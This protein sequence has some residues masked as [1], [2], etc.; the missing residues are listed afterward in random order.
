MGRH[1]DLS[2][3]V[4]VAVLWGFSTLMMEMAHFHRTI[5]IRALSY[6]QGMGHPAQVFQ[7]QS[8]TVRSGDAW[9]E[10]ASD[11]VISERGKDDFE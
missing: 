5:P 1:A 4:A 11:M 9:L 6:E 3:S 8:N 2:R 7:S 10:V